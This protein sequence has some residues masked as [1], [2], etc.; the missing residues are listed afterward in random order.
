MTSGSCRLCRAYCDWVVDPGG[1]IDT[2]CASL[3]AYD[4][5]DGRRIVGCVE[6]VFAAELDL[7]VV[8]RI[9]AAEGGRFGM[10]RAARR[11]L[12]VCRAGVE[13]AY[14]RRLPV[15][16]CINPEFAEPHDGPA[17]RVVTADPA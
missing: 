15:I 14:T 13:R 2:G 9:R 3:Y 4:D 6:R 5:S 17:F 7:T 16:G 12:P 11:P 10:L 8:G 1:C